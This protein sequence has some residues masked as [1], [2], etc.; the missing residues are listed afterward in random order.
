MCDFLKIMK[1]ETNE[2]GGV[3]ETDKIPQNLWPNSTKYDPI[4]KLGLQVRA[5]GDIL[6][7][8]EE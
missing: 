5:T 8:L 2:R 1:I 4:G 3:G 6:S 7:K